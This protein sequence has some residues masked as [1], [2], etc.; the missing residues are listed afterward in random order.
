MTMFFLSG[1]AKLAVIAGMFFIVSRLAGGA[2]LYFIQGLAT[3]YLG[4]TGSGIR[5]LFK[6]GPHGT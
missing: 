2:A 3:A 1:L 5:R 6:S 4:M